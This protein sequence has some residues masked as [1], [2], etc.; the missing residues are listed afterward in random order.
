MKT[1]KS[2]MY[3]VGAGKAMGLVIGA[4]GFFVLPML[5]DEPSLLLRTGIFLWYPTLGAIIGM[6]GVFAYH[7]ILNFPMPWWLRG[8]LLGGWMN[9][10]LTLFAYEQICTFVIAVFGEYAEYIS[11]FVMVIEGALIG[12]LMDYFLTRWFGEG[13]ADKP[14]N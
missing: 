2:L 6:F 8:A 5:V 7:P 3:R 12:L 9:F 10:L 4:I 14:N 11:P 13:W 1:D